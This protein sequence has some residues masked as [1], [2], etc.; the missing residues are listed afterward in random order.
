MSYNTPE[1]DRLEARINQT[2]DHLI[3]HTRYLLELRR[4]ALLEQVRWMRKEP[5][6]LIEQL[7]I[8]KEGIEVHLKENILAPIER[9]LVRKIDARLEEIRDSLPTVTRVTCQ[10]NIPELESV[11]SR[12][13]E[14]KLVPIG[15]P[16]YAAFQTSTVATG[17]KGRA[18]GEL[19]AP[20]G[21]AIHE[22]TQQIFVANNANDRVEIF[23]D[24]GEY[25]NQLGEG[26]LHSPWGIATHGDS[27]YVSCWNDH[28]VSKF[29]L[30]D[31][32]LVRK[33]G[34]EGS[35][36][37]QFKSPSQLTTDPIGH[38]FTPD[39]LNNRICI[40][41]T[42]LN[43]LRNITHKSMFLP[44]DV[45][46]SR[47]HLYVLCRT[48]PC[49]HVLTL[50]GDL[51]HSLITR[52]Q[53]MD[54]ETPIFFCLDPLYSFVI[55]DRGSHSICV[56]SP[57]GNLLHRIGREEHKQGMLYTPSGVAITPNGRLVCVSQNENYGLQIF[58]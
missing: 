42:D 39:S 5:G 31:M 51:R 7:E 38:V 32:S 29:S 47:D 34:G 4:V 45:K 48:N 40:H 17:K 6:L 50:E 1:V 43:H 23:S 14:V 18:P 10:F 8:T 9:K 20:A 58:Y 33:I 55:S 21:V 52:G 16:D 41:D 3:V 15:V 35:G 19:N 26:Q 25:I 46:V 57:E 36:N 54:V 53:G 2:I 30:T 37:G 28:T 49:M 44:L 27:V 12:V 13:G 22:T 24:T 56:F 11:I